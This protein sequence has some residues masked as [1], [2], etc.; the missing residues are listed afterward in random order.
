MLKISPASS[1]AF[2]ACVTSLKSNLLQV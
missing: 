2:F 1:E